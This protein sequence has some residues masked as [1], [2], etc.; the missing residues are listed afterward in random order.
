VSSE[1]DRYLNLTIMFSSK[2]KG[3]GRGSTL[4]LSLRALPKAR[5]GA[6][7]PRK[8]VLNTGVLFLTEHNGGS[9]QKHWQG[10]VQKG[11]KEA[12]GW[13]NHLGGWLEQGRKKG[14][15]NY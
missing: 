11:G 2:K 13:K 1:G 8:G 6:G 10:R 15:S 4:T 5:E 9:F 12:Q 14:R 3:G 7:L